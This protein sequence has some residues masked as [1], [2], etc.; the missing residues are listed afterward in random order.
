M[1][2]SLIPRSEI[3]PRPYQSSLVIVSYSH[4]HHF[5]MHVIQKVEE[6]QQRCC[7]CCTAVVSL[8]YAV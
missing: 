3:L 8:L 2:H 5:A 7:H 4:S 6:V 1:Y